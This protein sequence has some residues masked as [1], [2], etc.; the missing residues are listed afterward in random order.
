MIRERTSAGLAGAWGEGH[1]FFATLGL[2][3]DEAVNGS[4]GAE[5]LF[6]SPQ[7]MRR[8]NASGLVE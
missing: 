7:R 2:Q 8:R 4:T 1:T 5:G 3:A 6:V